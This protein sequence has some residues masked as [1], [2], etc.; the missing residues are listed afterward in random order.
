MTPHLQSLTRRTFL[1]NAARGSGAVALGSLLNPAALFA[2]QGKW[3][4]ILPAPLS[5][6]FPRLS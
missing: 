2:E 6:S 5:E 1:G 3:R 4:G